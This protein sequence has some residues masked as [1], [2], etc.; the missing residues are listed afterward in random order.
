M[1]NMA[2][3]RKVSVAKIRRADERMGT[4]TGELYMGHTGSESDGGHLREKERWS[5]Y[6]GSE[7]EFVTDNRSKRK[8]QICV[9]VKGEGVIRNSRPARRV[10]VDAAGL[11]GAMF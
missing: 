1:A 9:S 8:V 2:K 11:A 3:Q 10:S 4:S 5:E 7:A 6:G